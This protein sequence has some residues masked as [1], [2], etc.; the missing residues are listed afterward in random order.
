MTLLCLTVILLPQTYQYVYNE[1][2]CSYAPKVRE[3]ISDYLSKDTLFFLLG[4]WWFER[5]W[6]K[7][8][9]K[10]PSKTCNLYSVCFFMRCSLFFF[11]LYMSSIQENSLL[12]RNRIY[13]FKIM[14]VE[15]FF[16]MF[17]I[18]MFCVTVTNSTWFCSVSLF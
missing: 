17:S 11:P 5:S 18:D 4:W 15:S 10:S 2:K 1:H 3:C 14:L 7:S 16:L 6:W 9:Q 8:V 12:D 13:L